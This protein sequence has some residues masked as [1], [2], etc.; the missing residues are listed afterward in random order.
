M[1]EVSPAMRRA[2]FWL[3]RRGGDGVFD[4]TRVLVASGERSG[5]LGFSLDEGFMYSTWLKLEQAGL[6]EF[7]GGK[8][9]RGRV[10][11]TASGTA[12][13]TRVQAHEAAHG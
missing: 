11:L 7:Y 2:I 1:T 5:S 10:K 3:H 9:G 4:K 8:R 12:I 6:L 13:A